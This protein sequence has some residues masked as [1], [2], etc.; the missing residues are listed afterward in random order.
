MIGFTVSPLFTFCDNQ[1]FHSSYTVWP[2]AVWHLLVVSSHDFFKARTH[3]LTLTQEKHSVCSHCWCAWGN[4]LFVV[5]KDFEMLSG[6]LW[7]APLYILPN[8]GLTVCIR[9][10]QHANGQMHFCQKHAHSVS[11]RGTIISLYK[12]NLKHIGLLLVSV[13]AICI[14]MVP[15]R[16][17]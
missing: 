6:D 15:P 1:L 16:A 8:K 7:S 12:H 9:Q 11:Y 2:T 17:L 10:G 13:T 14:N 5:P 3:S 4:V